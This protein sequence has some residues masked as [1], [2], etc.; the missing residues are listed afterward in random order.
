M[1][2]EQP[3]YQGEHEAAKYLARCGNR[4]NRPVPTIGQ[5]GWYPGQA[6]LQRLRPAT[7]KRATAASRRRIAATAAPAF[8]AA[9]PNRAR[10]GQAARP[11][12]IGMVRFLVPWMAI[13]AIG[14]IAWL[15]LGPAGIAALAVTSVL[16][17]LVL[18]AQAGGKQ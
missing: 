9:A 14:W 8:H 16:F 10:T 12:I 17:L 13:A 2:K 15:V 4:C 18:R 7:E 1:K 3:H 5:S 11:A 6:T